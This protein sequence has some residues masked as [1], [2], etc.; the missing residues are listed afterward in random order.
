MYINIRIRQITTLKFNIDIPLNDIINVQREIL[1]IKEGPFS[2]DTLLHP[3]VI[4]NKPLKNAWITS[5]DILNGWRNINNIELI[6]SMNFNS[7]SILNN[8]ENTI[9][10]PHTIS[11]VF[12]P[13]LTESPNTE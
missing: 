4:S 5:I 10:N 8:T 1:N 12:I 2:K 3:I 13:F 9:T 7:V 11:M 6:K